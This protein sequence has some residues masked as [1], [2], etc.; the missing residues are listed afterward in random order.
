[1]SLTLPNCYTLE[2]KTKNKTK[3]RIQSQC[4]VREVSDRKQKS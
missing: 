4:S 3:Y 2:N 1:M